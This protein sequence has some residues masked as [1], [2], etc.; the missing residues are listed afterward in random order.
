MVR[1]LERAQLPALARGFALLGSGGGGSTSLVQLA[2]AES[3]I[4]PVTIYDVEDLDPSLPCLAAAFVG[5]TLLLGERLPGD[6]PFTPLVDSAER[7]L[8]ERIP[9]VC[10]LEGGGMNGLTPLFL[11]NERMVVDA[12]L[13]GRAVPNLDQMSLLVDRVPGVFAT[14]DTGAG[15][16]MVVQTNRPVDLER[17]IR[18]AVIQAG[19]TG[20][21]LFA[22]FS[23]GDLAEHSVK[24][25]IARALTLGI[26]FSATASASL[27]VLADSLSGR[28][29]GQGRITKIEAD[30]F[31]PYVSTVQVDGVAGE[32]H[33]IVSRSEILAFMTNGRVVASAPTII[34]VLDAIS[35]DILEV[36]D[37]TMARSIEIIELPAPEWWVVSA[38]RIRHVRPSAYGLAE[39][40]GA[41]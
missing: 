19:G 10:A 36:T 5:S 12:D 25:G 41:V 1:F 38:E 14:C 37:L 35:R 34:V 21:A 26:A 8:G 15:G 11:A 7:W 22:G 18:S 33:R 23:V 6:A 20:G 28:V 32:I 40:D 30:D 17:V 3:A 24:G 13:T 27:P 29:L 9:V 2:L 4:W 31:D 16:V 39:L